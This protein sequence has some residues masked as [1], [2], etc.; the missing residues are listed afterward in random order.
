[1]QHFVGKIRVFRSL[2]RPL[3]ML[4]IWLTATAFF[5]LAYFLSG[6]RVSLEEAIIF[7]VA[8]AIATAAAAAIALLVGGRRRWAIEAALPMASLVTVPVCLAGALIW[9][10]PTLSGSLS[11]TEYFPHYRGHVPSAVLGIARQ[12]IPTGVLLGAVFGSMIGLSIIVVRH[13]PRLLRWA[14]AGLLL[15]CFFGSAHI[16][17]F[18]RIVDFVVNTRLSGV[19]RLV[20]AWTI[21]FELASAIGATAGACVG[22]VVACGAVRLSD[23]S[24]AALRVRGHGNVDG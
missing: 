1:M 18:D 16:G 5:G 12:T 21:R 11:T 10:A 15:S 3:A 9:L 4:A 19:N 13:R 7:T 20:V 17:A 2:A 22:A 6:R 23:R 24:R 14:V 8:F